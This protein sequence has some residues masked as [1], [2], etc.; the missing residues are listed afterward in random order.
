MRRSNHSA[1]RHEL[2]VR[3]PLVSAAAADGFDHPIRE[4]NSAEIDRLS[5][6]CA[7]MALLYVFSVS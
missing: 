3:L 6:R 4:I 5:G 7:A 1:R 2:R